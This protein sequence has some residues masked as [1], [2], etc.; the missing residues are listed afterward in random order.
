MFRYDE[1]FRLKEIKLNDVMEVIFDVG[2]F[3]FFFFDN[4]CVLRIDLGL[5]LQ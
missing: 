5:F 1:L 4:S 3:F 2:N